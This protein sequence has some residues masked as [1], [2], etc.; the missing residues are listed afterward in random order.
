MQPR[1]PWI[2]PPIWEGDDP[3]G[4]LGI[5]AGVHDW[6]C[7]AFDL[8]LPHHKPEILKPETDPH[9]SDRLENGR[10]LLR[11]ARRLLARLGLIGYPTWHNGELATIHDQE[12]AFDTLLNWIEE[13]LPTPQLSK[14]QR[15][16][17]STQRGEGRAKLIAAL[18]KH[19][20]YAEGGCLNL[21]PIGNNELARQ[22]EV[23]KRTASA[24]FGKEFG[25][26]LKYRSMCQDPALLAAALKALNG[27]FRPRD[28]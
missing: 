10:R 12:L 11:N 21:E 26:H 27:E 7:G 19:H 18:T 24:F 6:V 15:A 22:A 16:K 3:E 28:F 9:H 14:P 4:D 17:R 13:R 1:I 2:R 23:A 8:V 20:K 25:G 5:L